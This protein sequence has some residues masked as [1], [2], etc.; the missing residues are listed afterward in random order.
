MAQWSNPQT[1]ALD[2]LGSNPN[3]PICK[4]CDFGQVAAPLCA[5]ISSFGN[6]HNLYLGELL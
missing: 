2:R 3:F 1:L 4:L 6:E 5:L